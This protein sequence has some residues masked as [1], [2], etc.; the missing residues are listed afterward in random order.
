V[1][2][3]DRRSR[4]Q[5][6]PPDRAV[7]H[8]WVGDGADAR[9]LGT[10]APGAVR[11]TGR[12]VP[13]PRDLSWWLLA[14]GTGVL[15]AASAA[16][17]ARSA[18]L[19]GAFGDGRSYRRMAQGRAGAPPFSRRVL[20]PALARRLG[21]SGARTFRR[22][23]V[24]S[25]GLA[26]AAVGALT[27]RVAADGAVPPVRAA[28]AAVA[29]AALVPLLPHGTRLAV[30]VPEFNDALAGALGTGWLLLLTAGPSTVSRLAP[31]AAFAAALAREQWGVVVPVVLA[32][33]RPARGVVAAH[34]AAVGAAAA[35]VLSRPAAP[36]S[37]VWGPARAVRRLATVPG[38][39]EAVWAATF[40]P[41]ALLALLPAAVRAARAGAPAADGGGRTLTACLTAAA[42]Q[43]VLGHLGGTD[44]PRLDSGALLP[45]LPA[46]LGVAARRDAAPVA[47]ALA[48]TVPAW[49]P[50]QPLVPTEAGYEAFY[51]PY[52]APPMRPRLLGDA[53]RR[54]AGLSAA[55]AL[56]AASRALTRAVLA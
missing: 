41:G 48:A 42:A 8:A 35:V 5:S 23:S 52:M 54:A 31:T 55:A 46:L 50:L 12:A 15:A 36:G 29:A 10:T 45:A 30:Q 3:A 24:P 9:T 14:G 33:T 7:G 38:A 25:V 18:P 22:V 16:R 6:L 21:G 17:L 34:L 11:G 44:L 28:G 4:D 1:R 40:V 39:G 2:H 37:E 51:L 47:L 49:R 26:A 43:A 13:C 56:L 53:A 32:G 19:V 20:G 27:A